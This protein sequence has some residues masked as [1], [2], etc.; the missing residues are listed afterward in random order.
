MIHIVREILQD[1]GVYYVIENVVGAPLNDPIQLDG[2]QFGLKTVRRRLFETNWPC[3]EPP[4]V[5]QVERANKFQLCTVAGHGGNG[6]NDLFSWRLAMGIAWMNK[7]ELAQAIPPK[8]TEY[9]GRQFL[10][11]H[12]VFEAENGSFAGKQA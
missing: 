3:S 4:K 11:W 7:K 6:P 8:Y 12:S 10:E 1:R 2:L 5:R 9:I